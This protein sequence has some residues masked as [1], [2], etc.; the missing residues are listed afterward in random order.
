MCPDQELG[1]TVTSFHEGVAEALKIQRYPMQ[2]GFIS[3][4]MAGEHGVGQGRR[5]VTTYYLDFVPFAVPRQGS[6]EKSS[7]VLFTRR[8]HDC[9]R[10]VTCPRCTR[11]STVPGTS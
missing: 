11:F 6:F 9:D 5:A 1:N 8:S 2:D 7:A 10:G 4:L 3:R